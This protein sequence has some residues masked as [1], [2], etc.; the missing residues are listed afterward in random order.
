M[1]FKRSILDGIAA[2]RVALAFRRWK[3]P[4]VKV[5]GTLRTPVGILKF[6]HV[7]QIVCAAITERDAKLAG[8]DTVQALIRELGPEDE[9]ALYRIAFVR[10]GDDPRLAL[11]GK[12]HLAASAIAELRQRLSRFDAAAAKPWTVRTLKVIAASP[13]VRA[14]DLAKRLQLDKDKFKINVRKL[15][16]LGLTESLEVG[17]RLSPRGKAF[18]E[19]TERRR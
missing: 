11:R 8:F 10:I 14:A 2:G 16:D 9:R 5:G 1:L 7:E 6:D 12:R 17:Y 15:K 13:A 4:A 3:R 19:Q 18:L